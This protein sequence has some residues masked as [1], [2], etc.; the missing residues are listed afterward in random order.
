MRSLENTTLQILSQANLRWR[1]EHEN[2]HVL[3]GGEHAGEVRIRVHGPTPDRV[4]RTDLTPNHPVSVGDTM[5]N[6]EPTGRFEN[7]RVHIIV[8]R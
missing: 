3:L 5:F 8:E 1:A 2:R 4:P 7:L 6:Q